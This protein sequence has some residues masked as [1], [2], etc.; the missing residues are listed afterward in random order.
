MTLFLQ[1][2]EPLTIDDTSQGDLVS[3]ALLGARS[4]EDVEATVEHTESGRSNAARTEAGQT[5]RC[6]K[7]RI[8]VEAMT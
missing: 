1:P 5:R 3:A 4:A 7:K 8:E 2:A 6:E